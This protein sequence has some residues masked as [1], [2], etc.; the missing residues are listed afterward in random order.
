MGLENLSLVEGLPREAIEAKLKEAK[1]DY[2]LFVEEKSRGSCPY[3]RSCFID[4]PRSA[5]WELS[6]ELAL[7]KQIYNLLGFPGHIRGPNDFHPSHYYY[8]EYEM[9]PGFDVSKL[10]GKLTFKNGH[11]VE[12]TAIHF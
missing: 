9:L 7:R 10:N 11:I 2:H 4:L 12:S 8:A 5:P 1:I 3:F 6:K